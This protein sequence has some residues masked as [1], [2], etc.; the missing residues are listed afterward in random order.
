MIVQSITNQ[1]GLESALPIWII[2]VPILTAFISIFVA[3]FSEVM[4]KFVVIGGSVLDFILV[5][6]M[7]KPV[8]SGGGIAISMPWMERFNLG[9]RV[10]HI[11]Y[12]M[13]LLV[14]FVWLLA[15]IYGQGYFKKEDKGARYDFFSLITMSMNLG[16][17]L[18]GDFL[19][20]FIF[21]EGL[22]IFPYSMIAHKGDDKSIKGANFYLYVG[23][24][25]GL[26]LLGGMIMLNYFTGSLDIISQGAK[27]SSIPNQA[28]YIIAFLMIAGFGGKAA[29][30]GEHIWVPRMYPNTLSITACLSSGAM[31]KAGAYGIFRVLNLIYSGFDSNLLTQEN[32]GYVLIMV[33]VV[34]MFLGVLNALISSDSQEM[35][36]YHSVSQMGYIMM[37]L[38]CAAYM[39]KDGAMGLSG[40][41]Y[42]IVNHSL[43]KASLFLCVGAVYYATGE[44]DMYKSGGLFKKM[45]LTA[46]C[47]LIA[48]LGISG[49]PGFNGFASK[50]LLHHSILEAYEHSA[51]YFGKPDIMLRLAEI[52]F[53]LTAAGTFASNIKLFILVFLG[54]EKEVSK[55]AKEVPVLMK[56]SLIGFSAVIIFLGLF[57]NWLLEH[58]IGPGLSAYGYDPSSHAYHLIY[59]IH[60]SDIHSTLPILYEPLTKAFFTSSAVLHNLLP[61]ATAIFF[62]GM[63]FILGMRFGW[64][65]VYVTEKFT[66]E[67]YYRKVFDGFK[68][69]C[70]KPCV[71]FAMWVRELI[72][73]L[74]VYIW[75]PGSHEG[76]FIKRPAPKAKG[77]ELFSDAETKF[78][79]VYDEKDKQQPGALDMLARVEGGTNGQKRP[80]AW[81]VFGRADTN[82]DN[83]LGGAIQ[84]Q[85]GLWRIFG[86]TDMTYDT[87]LDRVIAA[88][89]GL[90]E[91]PISRIEEVKVLEKLPGE[92]LVANYYIF[93]DANKSVDMNVI[94]GFVNYIADMT[95]GLGSILR[96]LQ[97]GRVSSYAYSFVLG[98]VVLM[99]V[100]LLR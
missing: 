60:A 28:K 99:A 63:Y 84:R 36:G 42:H 89:V 79:L 70:V 82:Y 38:G 10:D 6:L 31:I 34:T 68:Y 7:G 8:L 93:C 66:V 86:S 49:V 97:T 5:L 72:S 73:V 94:D 40:A 77:L 16:V 56:I 61:G 50:T 59:N 24:V 11:G 15:T 25:T 96:K 75:V 45:P 80:G 17:M 95:S 22:V 33:G 35:L 62:G 1:M 51:L 71:I 19:T 69:F 18:A 37:G 57:P 3:R 58:I 14:S 88:I 12:L 23:V 65:H 41:I 47:L 53:V 67:F 4:R 21:F 48:V 32:I 78:N 74:M 92:D 43:F 76:I 81:E 87:I 52:I 9:F 44:Q 29:L 13:V 46:I 100:L 55:D 54:K 26:M 98:A 85:G 83:M 27:L 30:F 39:G 20:L 91:I 64:F 2:L 90:E